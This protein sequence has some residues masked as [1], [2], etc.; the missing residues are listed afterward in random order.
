MQHICLLHN[1]APDCYEYGLA[2]RGNV[3]E[4]IKRERD[5]M[6]EKMKIDDIWCRGGGQ[7]LTLRHW[8]LTM[9]TGSVQLN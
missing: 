9:L 6:G 3:R 5:I 8:K 4:V 1:T 2:W 7:D